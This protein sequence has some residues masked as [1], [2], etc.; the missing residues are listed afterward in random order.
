MDRLTYSKGIV[1]DIAFKVCGH[2]C[3]CEKGNAIWA[4]ARDSK[5]GFVAFSL[6]AL[7][8]AHPSP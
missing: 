3:L 4:S 2:G 7:S 1:T 8:S 6:L 5:S